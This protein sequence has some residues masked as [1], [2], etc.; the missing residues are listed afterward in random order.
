MFTKIVFYNFLQRCVSYHV[1]T[2]RR[3]Q[4]KMTYDLFIFANF[5][6]DR[7]AMGRSLDLPVYFGDAGSREVFHM[8]SVLEITYMFIT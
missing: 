8:T 2:F 7:V 3:K 6:S 5:F 1:C 4:Q